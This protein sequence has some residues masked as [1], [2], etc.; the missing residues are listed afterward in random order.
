MTY[1]KELHDAIIAETDLKLRK[2]QFEKQ[3]KQQI[4]QNANFEELTSGMNA[5]DLKIM[6]SIKA[7]VQEEKRLGDAFAQAF[8]SANPT[9]CYN[10]GITKK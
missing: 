8:Q 4:E 3:F 5:S 6:E 7:D 2:A 9:N 10:A 1:A